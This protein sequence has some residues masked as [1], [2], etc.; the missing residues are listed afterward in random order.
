MYSLLKNTP[1]WAQIA[2]Y[3]GVILR[4]KEY[5]ADRSLWLDEA[6]FAL[7]IIQRSFWELTQQ[8]DPVYATIGFFW[9]EKLAVVIFGGSELSLR[10][11]P[12]LSGI[13]SVILFYK[14]AGY[15]V[16]PKTAVFSTFIF[17]IL[18]SLI[19]YSSEV[20]QYSFDLFIALL[21]YFLVLK[22]FPKNIWI[23]IGI[24]VISIWFSHPAIFVLAGLGLTLTFYSLFSKN[25]ADFKKIIFIQVLW[26]LSF[27]ASYL[28][29]IKLGLEGNQGLIGF[30]SFAFA[31]LPKSQEDLT[32]YFN[33]FVNFMINPLNFSWPRRGLIIVLIGAS[34]L[35]RKNKLKLALLTSPLV[36][37]LITS[38]L[39]VYPFIG[40]FLLFLVPSLL[41]MFAQGVEFIE[42]YVQKATP[43]VRVGSQGDTFRSYIIYS[44]FIILFF[45]KTIISDI[46]YL[47]HSR[48]SE[49]MES[50]VQYYKSKHQED[51]LV[52]LYYAAAPGFRYYS[53]KLGLK[54]AVIMGISSSE[55]LA[56]YAQDME[57]L[58]GS[59]RIWFVFSHV[60]NVK[61]IPDVTEEQFFISK[62]DRMG[63][64]LDEYHTTG[65][66]IYLYDLAKSSHSP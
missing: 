5:L 37:T 43:S 56:E 38:S 47:T 11:F 29:T 49:D 2:I 6:A 41:I 62:L 65:A 48:V 64:K 9:L 55:K 61:G 18:D 66:S 26:G 32:W 23:L 30:W 50:V 10:F 44:L 21:I 46:N 45:Y 17:S 51:D 1:F 22:Y 58:K 19:Y 35:L 13:S 15:F 40:R 24:G 33:A 12:L 3:L 16:S 57:K 8:M 27:L 53:Q 31:P 60:A 36:L 34:I 52:Y 20:K 7:F 63:K 42:S 54:S 25:W 28:T 59:R 39:H 4:L 14:V